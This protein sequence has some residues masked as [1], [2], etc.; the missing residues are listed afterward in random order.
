M[1]DL[2]GTDAFISYQRWFFSGGLAND[3]LSIEISNNGGGTWVPVDA[4]TSTGSAWQL[5]KFLVSDHLTPTANVQVRF[6]TSDTA[7]DSTTEAGIDDFQV[8]GIVC[9][10]DCPTDITGDGTTN[11]LD[12]IQLLL[13]FGQPAACNPQADINGDGDINVL[14]LIELLLAFGKTCP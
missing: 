6:F 12:L 14:D 2:S 13:C 7:N 9:G 5:H 10:P 8:E 3:Q 11:V 4:T 1:Q